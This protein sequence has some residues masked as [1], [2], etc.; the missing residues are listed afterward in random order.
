MCRDGA[1]PISPQLF[2]ASRRRPGALRPGRVAMPKIWRVYSGDDGKS[3][4]EEVALEMKPFVDTEGAYGE[5]GPTQPASSIAFRVSPPG[6]VLN[7]HCAP[8]RQYSIA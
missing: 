1:A 2:A 5:A 4:I 3:H 8:R 6:Y 7:W